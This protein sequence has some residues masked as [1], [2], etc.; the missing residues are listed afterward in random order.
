[1]YRSKR[2]RASLPV[3]TPCD[4]RAMFPENLHIEVTRKPIRA[5]RLRICPPHAAVRLS[6]PLHVGEAEVRRFIEA[7]TDWILRHRARML[8]RPHTPPPDYADGDTF[9]LWGDDHVLRVV[10]AARASL[11]LDGEALVLA[12]PAGADTA[13]R[14]RA[15]D[16]GLRRM[17]LART[18]P[19]LPLWSARMGVREPAVRLRNMKTRWGTCNPRAGR[20]WL[21]TALAHYP[22]ECLEYVVVHELAHLLE[23]GHGARFE[24]ILD[25]HLP[26]WRQTRALL[27]G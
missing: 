15:V 11:C 5:L 25:R 1:M 4:E 3:V 27:R 9:R 17:L 14:A 22:P 13:R 2:R 23:R 10:V 16:Q 21:S 24:A 6:V 18:Q 12:V 7:R 8:A 20:V 19:L 26:G